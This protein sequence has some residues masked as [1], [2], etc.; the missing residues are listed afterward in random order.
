MRDC[1]AIE[2]KHIIDHKSV[3]ATLSGDLISLSSHSMRYLLYQ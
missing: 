1:V 2:L 3:E